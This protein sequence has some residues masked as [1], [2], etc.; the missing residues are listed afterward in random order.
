M[1]E[2]F[3][4]LFNNISRIGNDASSF[5]ERNKINNKFASYNLNNLYNTQCNINSDLKKATDM[6]NVFFKGS[7]QVGP[8]GCNVDTYSSL[9]SGVPY[10]SHRDR[11]M[12]QQRSFLTVPYLGRGNCNVVMEARIKQG[13]TFKE[14]KSELQTNEKPCIDYKTY[15]INDKIKQRVNN[16]AYTIENDAAPGWVRGGM[17]TR[18]M[19]KSSSYN[20]DNNVKREGLMD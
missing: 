16:S 4:Y 13:D 1:S 8:N 15:P 5:T 3:D 9:I 19:Y 18:D 11:I 12:L 7:N 6:P 20:L 17:S 2:T 10:E 14:K